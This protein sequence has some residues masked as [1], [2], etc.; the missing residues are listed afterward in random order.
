MFDWGS[1]LGIAIVY[2]N[3]ADTPLKRFMD[4]GKVER[5]STLPTGTYQAIA[6]RPSGLALGF[7]VNE[8]ERQGIWLSDNEGKDP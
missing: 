2:A 1:P 7:I 3:G 8:G 5:L 4:D 6:Y